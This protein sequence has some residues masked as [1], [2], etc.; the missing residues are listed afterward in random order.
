MQ[1]IYWIASYPRSGNTWLRSMLNS[2]GRGG[3]SVDINDMPV[4]N[5]TYDR[6]FAD[7][8]LGLATSDL[9][10]AE[11]LALRPA[12]MRA[13]R[14]QCDSPVTLKT[15]DMRLRL[16]DGD[17]LL[18][19]DVSL[20]GVYLV[21]D[22]RDVVL[23][24]ARFLDYSIDDAITVMGTGGHMRSI[25]SSR[26]VLRLV[27]LWGSW[28]EHVSSWL[29]PEPFAIHVVRYEDLRRD[30]RYAMRGILRAFDQAV[31]DEKIAAAVDATSLPILRRQEDTHGF[32]E[33]WGPNRFFGSGRIGGWRTR[34]TAGQAA[35]I[36]HDHE[37]VMLR[38]G[39]LD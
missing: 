39:Y 13:V 5:L 4:S 38:L 26:Q 17:W 35:R 6:A 15:H 3:K 37:A 24:L 36:R 9:T 12:V 29:S 20:G 10:P 21:R 16:A 23:S 32:V 1:G 11:V 30:P 14:D 22:P 33:R 28:S 34:L 2:Y 18:P 19:A 25:S 8:V 27:S 7:E 31:D